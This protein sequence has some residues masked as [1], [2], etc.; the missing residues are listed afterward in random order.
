MN[1][2]TT[3]TGPA[4]TTTFRLVSVVL[5][6]AALALSGCA[7]TNMA[8]ATHGNMAHSQINEYDK[9]FQVDASAE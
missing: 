9:P 4:G 1:G 5:S 6:I 7:S 3:R 8:S 2:T